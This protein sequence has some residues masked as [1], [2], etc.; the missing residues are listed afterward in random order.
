MSTYL[1]LCRKVDTLMGTQG[2]ISS[3]NAT[4]YQ[5]VL[6]KY[7]SNSWNNIQTL[8]KDWNFLRSKV[9]ITLYNG[10][11]DYTVLDIF[12][13]L[14]DPVGEWII[15]KFILS[16]NSVMTYIPY[17]KWITM[18]IPSASSPKY[19]TINPSSVG[20]ITISP[21]DSTYG[22]SAHFFR[23]PQ[24]LLSNEDIPICP[25]EYHDAI[26]FTALA[27]L[28]IF[29]GNSEIAS[30]AIVRSDILVGNLMRSENPVK[31]VKSRSIC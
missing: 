22:V 6:C 28:A 5:S 23:K 13:T 21:V 16:D 26:T 17:D 31:R 9:E 10:Q 4:G 12:G 2:I 3:V 18:K 30:S 1:E 24:E 8:R 14:V 20:Y 29:L 25:S 15:D 11:I 7:V 19:F 27:D